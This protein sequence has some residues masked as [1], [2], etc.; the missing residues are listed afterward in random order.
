[1]RRKNFFA[2]ALFLACGALAACGDVPFSDMGFTV[3][4]KQNAAIWQ[5][6]FD[7]AMSGM[8]PLTDVEL[9]QGS[10]STT[11]YN[12]GFQ[13]GQDARSHPQSPKPKNPYVPASVPGNAPPS[14]TGGG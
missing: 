8:G 12:Q 2:A 7:D 6:G 14:A 1:M 11:T 4:P 3:D 5:K 13:A 10:F 9:E